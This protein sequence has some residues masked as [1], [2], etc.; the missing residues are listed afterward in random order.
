MKIY[1]I[2]FLYLWFYCIILNNNSY[3]YAGE[4]VLLHVNMKQ[5]INKY[6]KIRNTNF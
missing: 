6:N 3:L 4:V 5:N 2:F 1:T